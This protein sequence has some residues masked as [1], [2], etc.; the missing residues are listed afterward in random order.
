[1]ELIDAPQM[2]N[3]PRGNYMRHLAYCI[4]SQNP[5]WEY[6]EMYYV[7][8]KFKLKALYTVC[9]LSPK[10]KSWQ[11]YDPWHILK[12]K[13]P[14][15]LG[16]SADT[17]HPPRINPDVLKWWVLSLFYLHMSKTANKKKQKK[18]SLIHSMPKPHGSI[19]V[20]CSEH[21]WFT[22]DQFYIQMII[23]TFPWTIFGSWEEIYKTADQ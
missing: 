7:Q 22:E 14:L 2:I 19:S 16:F 6:C 9:S 20:K 12:V 11:F 4:I 23:E 15:S 10:D 21:S 1:M 18:H 17:F 5:T 13:T 8:N 3:P